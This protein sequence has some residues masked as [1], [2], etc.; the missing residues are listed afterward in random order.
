MMLVRY[1]L[2][3]QRE[4]KKFLNEAKELLKGS[5]LWQWCK[6][7]KGLGPVAA[8]TFHLLINLDVIVNPKTGVATVGKVYRY[9]RL[10]SGQ[11][12]EAEKSSGF[13]TRLK[14]RAHIIAVSVVR[15]KALLP[16]QDDIHSPTEQAH[17]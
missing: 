16:V 8:V 1:K 11:K 9:L 12:I 17:R 7:V 6:T 5:E 14:G 15:R 3:L 4:E 2:I 10:V 13:N